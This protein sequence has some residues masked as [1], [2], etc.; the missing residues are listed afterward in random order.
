[1]LTRPQCN[2][3]HTLS[4]APRRG[5]WVETMF[6]RNRTSL[7]LR[8]LQQTLIS[9]LWGERKRASRYVI[10]LVL[11]V[12]DFSRSVTGNGFRPRLGRG[13]CRFESCH[14]DHFKQVP[15]K[16]C[17][18]ILS[19]ACEPFPIIWSVQL[20]KSPRTGHP[21]GDGFH[22]CPTSLNPVHFSEDTASSWTRRTRVRIHLRWHSIRVWQS[23]WMQPCTSL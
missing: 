10:W 12:T 23:G 4:V 6:D 16:S 20:D 21:A 15:L 9:T 3:G 8:C 11:S 17:A 14:S 7:E 13:Q 18:P 22:Q 19:R 1:M 2:N 5:A